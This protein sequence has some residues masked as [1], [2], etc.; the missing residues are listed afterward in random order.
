MSAESPVASHRRR[1]EADPRDRAAFEALE[2][3]H[4]LHEEWSE[5]EALYVRRLGAETESGSPT[6]QARILVRLGQMLERGRGDHG[7]ALLRYREAAERAPDYRPAL[8]A[9]R[10]AYGA[11]GSWELVLQVAEQEL[12]CPIAARARA[13]L[14]LECGEIWLRH[15]NDPE[16]ALCHFQLAASD[17]PRNAEAALR[18]ASLLEQVGRGERAIDAYQ[19]AI[20]LVEGPERARA[21]VALAR[22]VEFELDDDER[23][24]RLYLEATRDEPDHHEALTALTDLAARRGDWDEVLVLQE[25]RFGL[26][27][28]PGDQSRIAYGAARGRVEHGDD[29]LSALPW[30]R[31]AL[32]R[33]DAE[34]AVGGALL[35]ELLVET[36]ERARAKGLVEEAAELFQ[37]GVE[38]DRENAA[39]LSGLA[40]TRFDLGDVDA[41]AEA[42]QKRLSLGTVDTQP[43]LHRA[44]AAAGLETRGDLEEA[45]AGYQQILEGDPD[46]D[47]ALAGAIRILERQERWAEAA[48][49]VDRWAERTEE[50]KARAERMARAARLLRDSGANDEDVLARLHEGLS[51]D[52]SLGDAW[53]LLA[54]VHYEAGNDEEALDVTRRALAT[55][56][57]PESRTR[58]FTTR[59]T[60]LEEKGDARS[61]ASAWSAAAEE[62]PCDPQ[63]LSGA[64]HVLRGLGDWTTAARTI[65]RVAARTPSD[66][67][68]RL[69]DLY[70]E[71][72]KLRAGPLEDMTA[73]AEAYR[74]SLAHDPD[75]ED[76][77]EA[78]EKVLLYRGDDPPS[79]KPA[80]P[81]ETAN[82]ENGERGLR[83]L[84]GGFL[85]NGS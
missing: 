22:L 18:H 32:A 19:H 29:P 50:P 28:D 52:P 49:L 68:D 17:D 80:A 48:A 84:L 53:L 26:A 65:E 45:L 38:L 66:R 30:L 2:E 43:T 3:H 54:N 60:L 33:R 79:P 71:L 67:D 34:G 83:G 85:K 64:L 4:Y 40:E 13:A 8:R 41:A 75:R 58:L 69:A 12:S 23:A 70:S 21:R 5:L 74:Q 56:K 57:D 31:E 82:E 39:A 24:G 51:R 36:A 73:A 62:S 55:V 6:D 16:Q 15:A 37:W 78:L 7:A 76:V 27:S 81:V 9:L 72:G 20:G 63:P 11:V 59:A 46:H 35:L 25:R 47:A 42:V 44:I 1:L 77:R 14:H 10:Q 61:A